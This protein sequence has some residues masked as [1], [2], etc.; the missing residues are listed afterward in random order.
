MSTS[1]R[2]PSYG[3]GALADVGPSLLAALGV[4]GEDN[5]LNLAETARACLLLVDGLGYVQLQRHADA[6]PFLT[7]MSTRSIDAGFP[8][9]TVTSLS[10]LGTGLPSGQHGL[11][12]Y[13]SYDDATGAVVNWLAWRSVGPGDDL[14]DRLGPQGGPP[15][16]TVWEGAGAG[17][18]ATSGW[19]FDHFARRC[20][21]GP[22]RPALQR[23]SAPSTTSPAV[24]SR[25]PCCVG[26][27]GAGRWPKAMRWRAPPTRHSKVIVLSSTSMSARSI[28]SGTCAVRTPTR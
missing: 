24:D 27:G 11:T 13:S 28:S 25:G 21:S 15:P 3:G 22:R 8:A 9:T 5:A 19:N 1:V 23:R 7:S 2:V 4:P 12:G 20:G 6:A 26:G 18:P 16:P 14:R 10:S 17:G